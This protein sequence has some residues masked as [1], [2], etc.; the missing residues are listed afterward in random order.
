M[1]N[2]SIN[3]LLTPPTQEL[4]EEDI[5]IDEYNE[6]DGYKEEIISTEPEV[7]ESS[8]NPSLSRMSRQKS[9][10]REI[11]TQQIRV[12]GGESSKNKTGAESVCYLTGNYKTYT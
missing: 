9:K 7:A 11:S 8:T 5:L 10:I 4:F 6:N 2:G 3:N 12:D 1:T